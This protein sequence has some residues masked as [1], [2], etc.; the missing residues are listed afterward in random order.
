MEEI[1]TA[2]GQK[3]APLRFAALVPH[4]DAVSVLERYRRELFARGLYGA[5]SFPALVPLAPLAAP[6][7][8]GGLKAAAASFRHKLGNAHITSGSWLPFALPGFPFS[9]YGPVFTL[10]GIRETARGILPPAFPVTALAAAVLGPEDSALISGLPPPPD[11]SFRAAALTVVELGPCEY[12]AEP[13]SLSWNTGR[14][15]WLPHPA[16]RQKGVR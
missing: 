4:R 14:L 13:Y 6:P 16:K 9:L 11:I 1:K 8:D 12:G 15:F 10:P 5:F 7:E 2:S 3:N